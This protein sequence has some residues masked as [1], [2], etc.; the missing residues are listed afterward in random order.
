[1]R[2]PQ[3]ARSGPSAAAVTACAVNRPCRPVMDLLSAATLS[4][5][6][7]QQNNENGHR[8]RRAHNAP[9]CRAAGNAAVLAGEDGRVLG[10]LHVA[11]ASL[12]ADR[13]ISTDDSVAS[14]P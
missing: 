3:T 12:N 13:N 4:E 2:R 1:M 5:Q 7:V 10:K 14:G 8:N 6:D 9:E 11:S